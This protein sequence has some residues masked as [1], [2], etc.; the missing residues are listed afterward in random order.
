MKNQN[1]R[2]DVFIKDEGYADV[3]LLSLKAKV[4]AHKY[5]IPNSL[6]QF[7][8]EFCGTPV[9]YPGMQEG[10]YQCGIK[11]SALK[12]VAK[13]MQ[14]EGLVVESEFSMQHI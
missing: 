7:G 8:E 4:W 6:E 10:M 12:K 14:K 1:L 9:W 13:A 11:L 2:P 3:K 5:G